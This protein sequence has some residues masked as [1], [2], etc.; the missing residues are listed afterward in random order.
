MPVQT[1][2]MTS[3]RVDPDEEL[4][5]ACQRELP[6]RT[7]AFEALVRRYEPQVYRTCLRIVG[8]PADA[9]DAAQE[10]FIRVLRGLGAF[11]GKSS[12]RT[13]LFSIAR[14]ECVDLLRKRRP[15]FEYSLE[16]PE[17]DAVNDDA[18]VAEPVL[19]AALSADLLDKTLSALKPA[20]REVLALRFGAEL[21]FEALA[22]TLGVSLSA[23]KMRLYRAVEHFVSVANRHGYD[24]PA[25]SRGMNGPNDEHQS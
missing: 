15:E 10:V 11:E 8:N 13:W 16:S 5:R 12:F 1:A 18:A 23:A 17:A 21:D 7:R 9:E 14:N 19:T 22:S 24:P 20:E 3:D 6:H 4:V 2:L 25:G